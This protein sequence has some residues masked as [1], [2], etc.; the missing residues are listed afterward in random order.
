[1]DFGTFLIQELRGQ[2]GSV[3]PL[4]GSRFGI[5]PHLGEHLGIAK[6]F[7]HFA[8]ELSGQIHLSDR[9]I[10]ELEAERELT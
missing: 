8:V 5:D 4:N 9:S 6:G 3:G 10:G 1:M 2:I 7:K